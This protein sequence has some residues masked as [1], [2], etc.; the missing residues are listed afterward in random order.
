MHKITDKQLTEGLDYLASI[1]APS[2]KENQS[3]IR[4]ASKRIKELT[5]G[6]D[7]KRKEREAK[8]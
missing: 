2:Y 3:I 6:T 4:L 8:S 7:P 5:N 1:L